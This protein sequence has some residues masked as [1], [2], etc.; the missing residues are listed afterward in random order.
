M[1]TTSKSCDLREKIKQ[2]V[3]HNGKLIHKALQRSWYERNYKLSILEEIQLETMFLDAEA[4]LRERLYYIEFDLTS[5]KICTFCNERQLRLKTG[6]TLR[7]FKSCYNID[8]KKQCRSAAISTNW[9][10]F[11]EEQKRLLKEKIRKANLGKK[12]SLE[13]RQAQANRMRG[14]KQSE[15]TVSKR[16]NSRKANGT[17]WIT[18][19]TK[20]KLSIS[21]KKVHTSAEFRA[22]HKTTYDNSR[23]KQSATMKTKIANGSFTPPITNSWTHWSAYANKNG[24]TK[25][26]RSSWEA[27]FWLLTDFEYEKIRVPYNYQG[28]ER[29]YIV[30]F[31][32]SAKNVIFEIKPDSIRN[33]GVNKT[34]FEAATAWAKQNN[35]TFEII[36]NN[37]FAQYITDSLFVDNEHLR[38]PL[39]CFK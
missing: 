11:T 23:V 17:P 4:S 38:V 15:T 36:G 29:V 8:C 33:T 14:R 31:V 26:F 16:M 32:D 25:R 5:P 9:R 10:T 21:N 34:K 22:K 28:K 37:W 27:A 20:Q 6:G 19:E 30:D 12:A 1:S 24:V 7:F 18:E 2:E 35:Y 3:F 39:R 13:V